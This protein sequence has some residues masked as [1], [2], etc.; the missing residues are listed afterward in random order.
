MGLVLT[1]LPVTRN[2]QMFFIWIRLQCMSCVLSLLDESSLPQTSGHDP[3]CGFGLYCSLTSSVNR[4]IN[5]TS[6]L[7]Q[8][9]VQADSTQPTLSSRFSICVWERELTGCS[10]QQW[11]IIIRRW[12][13][14]NEVAVG[15][16][17]GISDGAISGEADTAHASSQ[18]NHRSMT[19]AG[20]PNI[21]TMP[22][23][24]NMPSSC[25]DLCQHIAQSPISSC[26]ANPHVLAS[27]DSP[28]MHPL[29]SSVARHMAWPI[30]QS[31]IEAD[32]PLTPS[33]QFC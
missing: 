14:T 1:R 4:W 6:S 33:S 9:S 19:A 23:L 18:K 15:W 3:H 20:P 2:L 32:R 8:G 22:H 27:S 11:S 13:T 29:R 28:S 12:S 17:R 16:Q 31:S 26:Q 30:D 24:I 5:Q 21:S 10:H 7:K 25:P